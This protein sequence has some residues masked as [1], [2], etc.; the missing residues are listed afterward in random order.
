[1][2]S[3]GYDQI[4]Y[5]QKQLINIWIHYMHWQNYHQVYHLHKNTKY[6][7][8]KLRNTK[9]TERNQK[10]IQRKHANFRK[11]DCFRIGTKRHFRA[12]TLHKWKQV[13]H[14]FAQICVKKFATGN[15]VITVENKPVIYNLEKHIY[16]TG[17]QNSGAIED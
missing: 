10:V 12:K 13:C 17:K 5:I 11:K 9:E 7:A 1:M 15:P 6:L 4:V 3:F 14:G 2:L 16:V 8:G